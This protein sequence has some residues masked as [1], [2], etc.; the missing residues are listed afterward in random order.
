MS[1]V[2]K[3]VY[4]SSSSNRYATF[5]YA[6]YDPETRTLTYVNGGHNPPLVFR[7]S[8]QVLRLETGGPVVGLLPILSYQEASV[9]LEAGDMLVAFTDGISEAMNPR[10]EEWG[11][12]RLIESAWRIYGST[13]QQAMNEL[14]ASADRFAAGATQHD[15]M[16][17]MVARV[18]G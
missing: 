12:D 3:L 15:D 11:E 4:E 14:L 17:I 9:S 2:N 18:L 10:N 7:K 6:Q 13:A 16:T 5:F 1:N 8:G